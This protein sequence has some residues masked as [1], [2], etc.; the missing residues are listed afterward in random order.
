MC[1]QLPSRDLL[2]DKDALNRWIHE[3]AHAASMDVKHSNNWNCQFCGL[4]ARETNCYSMSYPHLDPPKMTVY[5]RFMCNQ[6]NP[7]CKLG[8]EMTSR[9]MTV[10]SGHTRPP[11]NPFRVRPGPPPKGR[12]PLAASCCYCKAEMTTA[13]N[14]RR[15]AG[16]K[17]TRYCG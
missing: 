4:P 10:A 5:I 3:F 9:M 6:E 2:E 16:C 13:M 17:L 12:F 14:L 7:P 1:P 11:A 8:L 15:C